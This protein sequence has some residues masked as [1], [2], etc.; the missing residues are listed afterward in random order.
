MEDSKIVLNQLAWFKAGS[1]ERIFE[2]MLQGAVAL[3]EDSVYLRENFVDSVDIM[4]Y[5]LTNLKALPDL[6]RSILSDSVLAETVR[7]NAYK[8]AQQQH[9]WIHRASAVLDDLRSHALT[10]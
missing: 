3:T 2:A 8:K 5:S 4:F 7:R 1:S 9:M 6:V 10:S